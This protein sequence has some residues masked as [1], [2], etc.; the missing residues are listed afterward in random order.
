[1][2]TQLQ[3][4]DDR[5]H[6]PGD[7]AN[8][9]ES[10]YFNFH[11]A[12]GRAGLTYITLDAQRLVVDRM[13][14]LLL[15]EHSGTLVCIRQDPILGFE[16]QVLEQGVLQYHCREPLQC[17]QLLGEADCL[18]VPSGQ[19]ISEVLA[20]ERTQAAGIKH[21]PIA[22]DLYFDALSPPYKFPSGAWDFYGQ[23]QEHFE[24]IG[25]VTG[26]LRVDDQETS[27][28]GLGGRDRSWGRRE[29]LR[30]DWYTWMN[31]QFNEDFFISAVF[32]QT[33]G[34][35]SS[36]GF[37]YL[38]GLIKP[39]VQIILNVQRDPLDRHLLGG[40][41]HIVVERGET[42]A[43][44]FSPLSFLYLT[45]TRE[46]N[47]QCYGCETLVACRCRGQMGRGF[48]E[49]VWREQVTLLSANRGRIW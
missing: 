45:I 32:S 14:L 15:P 28:I 24:Q 39:V 33:E 23:G 44:T 31:L 13:I 35:E 46:G 6:P 36:S 10:F 18:H 11:D 4:Q 26:H 40:Y 21:V 38:G 43:V 5:L 2:T 22:F 12:A 3:S 34:E 7:T 29:W 42:F 17:W 25:R 41:A 47:W 9:R 20:A 27:F 16:D 8:W 37:V 30:P 48:V 19:D 1:M 49:Y